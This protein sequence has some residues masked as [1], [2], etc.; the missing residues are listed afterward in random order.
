MGIDLVFAW[1][2]NPIWQNIKGSTVKSPIKLCYKMTSFLA[3][4]CI[5]DRYLYNIQEFND[6][7]YNLQVKHL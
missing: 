3:F 6:Y 2:F 7:R 5:L 1:V 4:L